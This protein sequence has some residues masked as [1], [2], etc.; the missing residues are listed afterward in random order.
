MENADRFLSYLLVDFNVE[1]ER[2]WFFGMNLK[3]KVFLDKISA[4]KEQF[5]VILNYLRHQNSHILAD[6]LYKPL[7]NEVR[8]KRMAINF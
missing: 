6:L 2:V 4:K 7:L 8:S 5:D 3:L 1:W